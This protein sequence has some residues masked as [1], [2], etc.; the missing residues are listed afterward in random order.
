[1]FNK[2]HAYY[3]RSHNS[4]YEEGLVLFRGEN[5][6]SGKALFKSL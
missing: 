2:N 6:L 1:M 3:V 4:V 5:H